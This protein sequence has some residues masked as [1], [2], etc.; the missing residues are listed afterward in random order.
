MAR[1]TL[2]SF[3]ESSSSEAESGQAGGWVE[4][5]CLGHQDSG[6]RTWEDQATSWLSP[7]PGFG[8]AFSSSRSAVDLHFP[9][10]NLLLSGWISG[11]AEL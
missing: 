6:T 3:E 8:K 2:F 9:F 5:H 11:K 7:Q 10:A 1:F 4:R